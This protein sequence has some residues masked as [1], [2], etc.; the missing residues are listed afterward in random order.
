MDE[1]KTNINWFPGHMAKTRKD[2]SNIMS[3]LDVII[4]VI[5]SRIPL[6]SRIPDLDKLTNNKK[7]VIVFNKYDLCDKDVTEKWINKYKNEGSIVVTCDSKNSKDYKKVIEAVKNLMVEVNEKRKRKGL[8]PKKAKCMVIGVPNVGKS[9]LIN[10]LVGKN[11]LDVGSGAGFPGLPLAISTSGN[12]TLID[13]TNKKIGHICRVIDEL[14]LDN[15][16]AVCARAEDYA[17]D[18]R[19][20]YD[21][22]IARAVSQLSMLVELCLPLVKVGGSFRPALL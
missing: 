4:E 15:A 20:K 10:K 1:N 6:S 18:N 13:S 2:I 7:R 11:V 16:S 12:Y 21:Y 17:K 9:T 19:E 3:T 5:D 22:V 14:K 8:L